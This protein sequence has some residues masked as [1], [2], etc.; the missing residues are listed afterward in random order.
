MRVGPS[1]S[2][3]LFAVCVRSRSCSRSCPCSVRYGSSVSVRTR[4][5][6]ALTLLYSTLLYSYL[7]KLTAAALLSTTLP[8]PIFNSPL[9]P[10]ATSSLHL[11]SATLAQHGAGESHSCPQL[12]SPS[13]PHSRRHTA[14]MPPRLAAPVLTVDAGK[15]HQIDTRNVENLHSMWTGELPSASTPLPRSC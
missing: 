3:S 13:I 2:V 4:R 7:T 8:T 1:V 5:S 10:Q 11:I 14:S 15:M 12:T 9:L 6:S